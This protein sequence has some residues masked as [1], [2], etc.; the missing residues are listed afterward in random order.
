MFWLTRKGLER[1][2]FGEMAVHIYRMMIFFA[3]QQAGSQQVM[4]AFGWRQAV[5]S[6]APKLW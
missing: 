1:Q 6:W 3:A 4:V 5:T 2:V